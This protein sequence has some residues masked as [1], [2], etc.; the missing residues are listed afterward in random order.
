M[1]LQSLFPHNSTING[2]EEIYHHVGTDSYYFD[3]E[4]I[5][6]TGKIITTGKTFL[7]LIV[8]ADKTIIESFVR[9]LDTFYYKEHVYLLLLDFETE[10]VLLINQLMDS[11]DGYCSWR[12]I[13]FDYLKRKVEES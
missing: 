6:S 13:D 3:A 12:L 11:D 1:K 4:G 5:R 10:K 9:L 8:S 2:L 7:L